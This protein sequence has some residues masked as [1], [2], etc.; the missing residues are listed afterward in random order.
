MDIVVVA[1]RRRLL[2]TISSSQF[3]LLCDR[4]CRRSHQQQG[5]YWA[6]EHSCGRYS[7]HIHIKRGKWDD[8]DSIEY[9]FDAVQNY[10][11]ILFPGQLNGWNPVWYMVT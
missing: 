2:L 7:R 4:C 5:Y 1:R 11:I 10:V 6:K 9:R 8:E 3:V